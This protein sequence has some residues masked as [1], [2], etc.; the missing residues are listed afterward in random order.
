MALPIVKE[1]EAI[2]VNRHNV[3][4][5]EVKVGQRLARMEGSDYYVPTIS[6][7]R[8]YDW[9]PSKAYAKLCGKKLLAKFLAQNPGRIEITA[10]G[11]SYHYCTGDM[12]TLATVKVVKKK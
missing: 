2:T 11:K 3:L 12:V 8:A 7:V 5:S 9:K 10:D 6:A 1:G 4:A